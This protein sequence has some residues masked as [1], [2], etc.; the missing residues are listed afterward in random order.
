M[1]IRT[2]QTVCSADK[3]CALMYIFIICE[4][5]GFAVSSICVK[6]QGHLAVDFAV[7]GW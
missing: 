1:H 7:R 3:T 4:R 6:Q 5:A 2:S